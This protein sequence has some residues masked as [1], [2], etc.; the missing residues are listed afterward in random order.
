[1]EAFQAY[2]IRFD[3]EK[4]YETVRYSYQDGYDAAKRLLAAGR[5]FT[6]LFAMA[7]I[8]AI[9]AIRALRDAGLRVPEDVSVMG[10]DG[11]SIGAFLVPQLSSVGQSVAVMARESVA[12]LL[13]CM[14]KDAEARH[15]VVP[16]TI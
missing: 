5:S 6:A 2:G 4:D 15:V 16:F 13:E 1:M 3:G 12:L 10:Y 11:L 14:E 9:G 8:L 7:D